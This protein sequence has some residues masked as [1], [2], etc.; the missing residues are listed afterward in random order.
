[1]KIA[2]ERQNDLQKLSLRFKESGNQLFEFISTYQTGY[3][4]SCSN[5]FSHSMPK[6][7]EALKIAELHQWPYQ[8]AVVLDQMA[9]ICTRIGQDSL[10]LAYCRQAIPEDKG[11]PYI[12]SKATQYMANAYWHLGNSSKGLVY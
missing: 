10:A 2:M 5:L 6:M 4:D 7:R 9:N 11:L 3:L 1:L 8:R 12:E